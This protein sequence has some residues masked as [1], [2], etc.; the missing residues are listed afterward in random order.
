[1]A[2]E[3]SKTRGTW[4]DDV[5]SLMKGN[6]ID[7]GCGN[8]PIFPGVDCFDQ[9]DGDANDISRYVK[10]QYDFVFSSH[11]LEHTRDP[12]HAL[13]EWFRLVRPGGHLIVLVPDEDLYEQ[14]V[15]PSA[16]NADHKFTFTMQK[17]RSWCAKSVNV[18]DLV[19]SVSGVLVSATL[20]DQ[21]YDRRL[22]SFGV[23]RLGIRLGRIGMKL[24]KRF[25]TFENRILTL[26]R[27]LGALIDQTNLSDGRL[28]QIQFIIRKTGE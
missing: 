16:F 13:Q 1:M 19:A 2:T 11:C 17:A 27:S 20:Q 18:L 8:D 25:P 28:A 26:F 4:N 6:G 21:R 7:I 23:G 15:F 24:G 14:G 22:M 5:L 9:V 10:K 12:Y 3:A